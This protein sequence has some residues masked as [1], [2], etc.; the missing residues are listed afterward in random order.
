MELLM[1]SAYFFAAVFVVNVALE[2]ISAVSCALSARP[3]R[4]CI[5]LYAVEL[6]AFNYAAVF[7]VCLGIY[8]I[9]N[10]DVLVRSALT[11]VKGW[12]S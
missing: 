2:A 3:V 1:W 9:V 10:V 5:V 6:E 4:R 11:F 8:I 12:R 7:G